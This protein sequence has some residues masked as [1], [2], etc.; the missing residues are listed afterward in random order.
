MVLINPKVL[1]F[2]LGFQLSFLATIGLIYLAPIIEDALKIQAKLK[3]LNISKQLA[4]KSFNLIRHSIIQKICA[5]FLLPILKESFISTISAVIFTAPLLIYTFNQF[6]VIGLLA[7]LLILWII[8]VCMLLGF[9]SALSAVIYLP[10]GRA[11]AGFAFIALNYVIVVIER[12]A[13][14][15]YAVLENLKLSFWAVLVSYAVLGAVIIFSKKIKLKKIEL[16][17]IDT[18]NSKNLSIY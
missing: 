18:Q 16:R 17:E 10:L 4:A 11:V 3:A 15:R 12:L 7:N 2:D 1:M 8:P 5:K 13:V 14:F 6:S 9:L